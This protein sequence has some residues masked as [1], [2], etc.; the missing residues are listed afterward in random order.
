MSNCF[1]YSVNNF[2]LPVMK[3]EKNIDS[4]CFHS[5]YSLPEKQ[6]K[7]YDHTNDLYL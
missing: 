6:N 5:S 4:L 1:I 3:I 2:R 7:T